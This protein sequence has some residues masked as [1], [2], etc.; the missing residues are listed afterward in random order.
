[1]PAPSLPV[2]D[3]NNAPIMA[4]IA[5]VNEMTKANNKALRTFLYGMMQLCESFTRCFAS[6]LRLVFIA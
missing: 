3:N 4:T 5:T 1:M 6:A 2:D